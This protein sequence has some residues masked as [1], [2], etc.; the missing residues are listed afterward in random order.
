M[1]NVTRSAALVV[2]ILAMSGCYHAKVS[3]GLAPS[4]Q[5]IDKPFATGWIYGLVPPSPVNAAEE[6]ENGV[7]MVETRLSF[8][9][10]LVSGITFGIFT[11][12]HIRVTCAAGAGASLKTDELRS[13]TLGRDR[14]EADVI[15]AFDRA[16]SM[17][18]DAQEPVLVRFE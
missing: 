6:C 18:V 1:K 12:M 16:A 17:A 2:L 10:Q 9:N 7:A 11:P 13:L 3:T 5:V 8:V 4:A 15:A 14:S